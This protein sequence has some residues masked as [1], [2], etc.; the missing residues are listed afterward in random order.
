MCIQ[1]WAY[2]D[3]LVKGGR[4]VDLP[5]ILHTIFFLLALPTFPHCFAPLPRTPMHTRLKWEL[6][7]CGV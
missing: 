3:S 5:E 1:A 7:G 6:R 4:G 2:G